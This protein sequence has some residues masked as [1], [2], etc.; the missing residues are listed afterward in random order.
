MERRRRRWKQVGKAI[1][2]MEKCD[3]ITLRALTIILKNCR[4]SFE[5]YFKALERRAKHEQR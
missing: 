5:A 2:L 1:R 3:G 4:A